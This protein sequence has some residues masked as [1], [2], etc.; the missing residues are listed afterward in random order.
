MVTVA[1]GTTALLGSV[2]TPVTVPALSA[3]AFAETGATE[4][5]EQKIKNANEI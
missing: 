4:I 5:A 3:C 2:T 1:L